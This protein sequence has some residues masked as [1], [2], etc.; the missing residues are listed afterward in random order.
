MNDA[1]RF[2]IDVSKDP[3]FR[4]ELNKAST[5]DQ[6]FE[7][8][9]GK[10]YDFNYFEIDDAARSILLKCQSE[11]QAMVVKEIKLWWDFLVGEYR[12]S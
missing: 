11:Q 10:N 9:K 4:K 3:V 12:S 2:I 6:L 5:E 8:V 1:I 7:I